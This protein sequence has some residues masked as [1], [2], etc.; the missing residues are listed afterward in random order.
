M[1]R[2]PTLR[3]PAHRGEVPCRR[4]GTEKPKDDLLEAVRASSIEDSEVYGRARP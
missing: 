1:T 2:Q 3:E 4:S